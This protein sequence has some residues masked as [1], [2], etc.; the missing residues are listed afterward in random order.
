MYVFEEVDRPSKYS[1]RIANW[2]AAIL[3]AAGANIYIFVKLQLG[4]SPVA[5]VQQ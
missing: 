3:F 4:F 5:V 2:M 1:D